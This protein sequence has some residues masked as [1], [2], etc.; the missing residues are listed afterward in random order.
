MHEAN[1]RFVLA[2]DQEQ[3][4]KVLDLGDRGATITSIIYDEPRGL[5]SYPNPGLVSW[6]KLQAIGADRLRAEP[7]LR[8]HLWRGHP[9]LSAHG[10]GG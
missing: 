7:K 10:L 5:A 1:V 4:D 2:E 6:E 3:V 8:L 9:C